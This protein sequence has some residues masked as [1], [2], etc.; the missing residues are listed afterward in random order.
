MTGQSV[1][2]DEFGEPE[3]IGRGGFGVVY[4]VKHN[5]SDEV[6][7]IKT[8]TFLA[9][10]DAHKLRVLNE[11]KSLENVRSE[12]VV[13]YYTSWIDNNR[14]YIQMEYCPQSL[15][16][17][18]AD[19]ALAFGRQS[20]DPMNLF[21]YYISCEIFKELLECVQYLH[22]LNPRVIH[23]DLK[24]D[25]VLIANKLSG[26]NNNSRR[27]IQLCDFGLA[28]VHDPSRHTDSRYQH[29]AVGTYK[30]RA[31]EVSHRQYNHKADIY[32]LS[33]IGQELFGID[34]H[35]NGCLGLGHNRPAPQPQEIPELRNQSIQYFIN[36]CDYVLAVNNL[37][38]IFIW[39]DYRVRRLAQG[40]SV[41]TN[42][43]GKPE[44]IGR[45]GFGVVYKVKHN[46]SDEVYAIKTVT[47]LASSDAHKLR[48]LNEV[49][50]LES[51]RSEYVVQYYTSWIDNNRLY[52]QMEY[53][54]QSLRKVL[55]DKALA[56]GRQ[57]PA[58]PMNAIEY[59]ISCEIFKELLESVQYLH[60]LV[61]RVI[62][63]D[64]KPDNILIAKPLYD[65]NN[66]SR[67]FIK[68]GDF[69]LATV[70]DPSRHKDSRY[71]HSA[72]GTN[73]YRAPEVPHRNYNQK[74]DIFSLSLI[75]Q[76]L[77]DIDLQA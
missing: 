62:H 22:E 9:S 28:T 51:V 70:H 63:R 33:L 44:L 15:R 52:I 18:L 14:L 58:E 11:V 30:Y 32:S 13:Q 50:S 69:G 6:Y 60:E 72:V 45:G 77:F 36:G 29:S 64:L 3:P 67:R 42:D 25:N 10:S 55:A 16:T 56:F 1:N 53:C 34:F 7:A 4:K 31:P 20:A 73:R 21:E 5:S 2:T 76:E 23:R 26:D 75:G 74:A 39:G 49:K 61:P 19:K 37:N 17:V 47:F 68:L 65:N 57:S 59:Y 54:P 35:A 27:F 46:S 24:P 12:Y 43:F 48:V 66:N 71:I 38:N 40:Q 8:V 41:N